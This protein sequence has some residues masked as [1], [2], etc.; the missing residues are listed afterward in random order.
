MTSSVNPTASYH[1]PGH[2]AGPAASRDDGQ[3]QDFSEALGSR[4]QTTS[5]NRSV[6]QGRTEDSEPSHRNHARGNA[7]ASDPTREN[8][9]AW[10]RNASGHGYGRSFAESARHGQDGAHGLS[11]A[12]SAD[13]TATADPAGSE[14][15][16]ELLALLGA[17]AMATQGT[18]GSATSRGNAAAGES[19]RTTVSSPAHAALD[20]QAPTDSEAGH[21]IAD[22]AT[23]AGG[24]GAPRVDFSARTYSSSTVWSNA[25]ASALGQQQAN[26]DTDPAVVSLNGSLPNS[27]RGRAIDFDPMRHGN[28]I[29]GR[30]DTGE[31]LAGEDQASTPI[32]GARAGS[33][34]AIDDLPQVEARSSNAAAD[35]GRTAPVARATVLADQAIPAPA[36]QQS[37]PTATSLTSIFASEPTWR[38]AAA[39]F[40]RMQMSNVSL[41]HSPARILKI[42]L[43]PESLGVVTANLRLV[44]EQLTVEMA[45]ESREAYQRLTAE[46]DSIAKAMRGLGFSVD[47]V[48]ITLP[49]IAP[50]AAG[51]LDAATNTPGHGAM[52]QQPSGAGDTGSGGTQSG[53][54]GFSGENSD[55]RRNGSA[56]APNDSRRAGGLYI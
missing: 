7:D 32:A 23:L 8:V 29:A 33:R 38:A 37:T 34:S 25:L 30:A 46:S 18:V 45:V 1:Q 36:I 2:M 4:T 43:T 47:Q 5:D 14:A 9:P 48:T 39:D 44:G 10:R 55:D 20:G 49:P 13:D 35:G 3:G 56:A 11:P 42:Q 28:L 53:R 31:V 24:A 27:A 51:R 50:S 40:A 21:P 41:S 54:Q 26:Q 22:E 19:G 17:D 6:S 16:A 12:D 15:A 52:G